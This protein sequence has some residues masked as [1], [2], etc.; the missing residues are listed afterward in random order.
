MTRLIYRNI[1]LISFFLLLPYFAVGS[2]EHE[3]VVNHDDVEL[4]GHQT[5]HEDVVHEEHHTD[6]SPLFFIII[7]VIIGALTR[8]FFQKVLC[9]LQLFYC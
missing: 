1:F 6:T 2:N 7:A 8:F 5:D 9:L 4:I 3:I